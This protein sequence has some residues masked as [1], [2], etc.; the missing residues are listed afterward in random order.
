MLPP[1]RIHSRWL[2]AVMTQN[3]SDRAEAAR[4]TPAANTNA[5]GG[6]SAVRISTPEGAVQSFL[7]G[8]WTSCGCYYAVATL[9]L[10]CS[11]QQ[12]Q[13]V[14]AALRPWLPTTTVRRRSHCHLYLYPGWCYHSRSTS[15]APQSKAIG[16]H[17]QVAMVSWLSAG[18]SCLCVSGRHYHI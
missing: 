12:Q 8:M 9:L 13:P 11:Q 18:C 14:S 3:D 10:L 1:G 7:G 16:R 2:C 15:S 6:T 4:R 17:V 5:R